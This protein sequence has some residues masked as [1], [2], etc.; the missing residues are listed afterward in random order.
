[1]GNCCCDDQEIPNNQPK[2]LTLF[3]HAC[4]LCGARFKSYDS[5]LYEPVC[6]E[7]CMEMLHTS[8]ILNMQIDCN[9]TTNL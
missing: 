8:N 6:S 1:M 4:M 9:S 3:N 2:R 7:H 5:Y